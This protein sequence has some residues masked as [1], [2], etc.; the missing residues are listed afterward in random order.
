MSG[1]PPFWQGLLHLQ[2]RPHA[3][4]LVAG[5]RA[6]ERPLAFRERP[7]PLGDATGGRLRIRRRPRAARLAGWDELEVVR[8]LAADRELDDRGPAL[9]RGA[10]E[11]EAE[12]G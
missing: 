10:R 2:R 8:V 6:V 4:L 12:L 3:C 5:Q 7:A 1:T 11:R 9:D